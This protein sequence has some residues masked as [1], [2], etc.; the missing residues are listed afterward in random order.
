MKTYWGSGGMAPRILNT[1]TRWRRVVSF[2]PQPLYLRGK[3]T[4]CPLDGRLG[5]PQSRYGRAGR[6]NNHY[7]CT[8]SNP[9]RP[10]RSSV[11]IITSRM[12]KWR[13]VKWA[14]HVARMGEM[15]NVYRIPVGKPKGKSQIRKPRRR[16]EDNFKIVLKVTG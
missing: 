10:D 14:S 7:H 8:K 16:W 9:C 13:K 15:R 2:T 6:E 3:S 12:F 11:T 1:G 5:G 4:R